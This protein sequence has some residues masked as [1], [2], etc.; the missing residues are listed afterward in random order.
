MQSVTDWVAWT[1]FAATYCNQESNGVFKIQLRKIT[2]L[3]RDRITN[4]RETWRVVRWICNSISKSEKSAQS[5]FD[6]NQVNCHAGQVALFFLSFFNLCLAS[7]W[8]VKLFMQRRKSCF[9]SFVEIWFIFIWA[10][11]YIERSFKK[12]KS[13]VKEHNQYFVIKSFYYHH[14]YSLSAIQEFFVLVWDY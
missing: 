1:F 5:S 8:S 7:I 9:F 12:R 3:K 13:T 14:L 2:R 6:V 4:H 11:T 10:Y